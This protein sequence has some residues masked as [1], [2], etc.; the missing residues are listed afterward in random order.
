ML[1]VEQKWADSYQGLKHQLKTKT[2]SECYIQEDRGQYSSVWHQ[3]DP[4]GGSYP[5]D[6]KA[7]IG[8]ETG[9]F[10]RLTSINVLKHREAIENG[11]NTK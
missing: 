4:D 3:G 8:K 11:Q 6:S 9:E 1:Y 10:D 2:N 7:V 5:T